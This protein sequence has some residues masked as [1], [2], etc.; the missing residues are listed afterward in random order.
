MSSNCVF[1][2]LKME[3]LRL[4]R[5]RNRPLR[6]QLAELVAYVRECEAAWTSDSP[7]DTAYPG[8]CG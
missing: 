3:D 6:L 7:R 2:A 4:A 8:Q 5:E 1:Y